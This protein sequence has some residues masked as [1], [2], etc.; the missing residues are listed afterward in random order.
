MTKQIDELM[1]LADE[2]ANDY[3]A[4]CIGGSATDEN[5][6][7]LRTALEAALKPVAQPKAGHVVIKDGT[8]KFAGF[9]LPD[10]RYDLYT[11]PPAQ[12]PAPSKCMECAN[13]DSWGLPDAPVCKFCTAGNKWKPL[14]VDSV[15]RNIPTA[16][17][18]PPWWPAVEAILNEYGLQAIDFVADWKKAQTPPRLMDEELLK[19]QNEAAEQFRSLA[20]GKVGKMPNAYRMVE[21]AVR[22]QFGVQE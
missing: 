1:R 16:Q 21:T 4:S 11:A 19:I 12:T 15:N 3:A 22:K 17:T 8:V 2:Y 10:G 7:A 9:E 14:N 6:T 18:P 20:N 13:G 5:R